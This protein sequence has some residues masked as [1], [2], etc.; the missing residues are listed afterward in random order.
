MTRAADSAAARDRQ[1]VEAAQ[2]D[3]RRFADL[4][5]RHFDRIYAFIAKRLRDRGAAEDVT[6]DVF[7][8]ALANLDRYEWRGIAFAAW[9]YRIAGNKVYDYRQSRAREGALPVP[10]PTQDQPDYEEA[11]RQAALAQAVRDLPA[12]QRQ[13]IELR[14]VKQ[15]SIREAAGEMQRSEG[16]IKQLQLRALEALRAALGEEEASHG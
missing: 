14:F 10:N 2:A 7:H 11:E 15:R 16:A 5:E 1:L 4:Y 13:V 6:S 9:L 12:D 8:H 3:P